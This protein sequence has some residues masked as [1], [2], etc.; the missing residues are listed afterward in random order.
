MKLKKVLFSMY[1]YLFNLIYIILN[2]LPPFLRN[3]FFKIVCKEF[4][5]YSYIDYGVYI[6][7]PSKM[8][9]GNNV[10][11]NR[12]CQFYLSFYSKTTTIFIDDNVLIG[13]N[14]VFFSAGHDISDKNFKDNADSI[15]INKNVWIGGNSTI[16][17]GVS[18][19]EGAVV[20]AGSVV[21]KNVL[22]Y[23]VVGGIP[24]NFIKNRELK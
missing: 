7:Y 15:I 16:L 19:G 17:Q 23:T 20:A 8:I 3:I 12:G 18:I 2:F 14:V 6:R 22:P 5:K 1:S 10:S 9:I 24:A 13:P 11:I 21:T 4:G